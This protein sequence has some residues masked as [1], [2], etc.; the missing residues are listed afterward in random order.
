MIIRFSFKRQEKYVRVKKDRR[1]EAILGE[2]E[3]K[4]S[5]ITNVFTEAI[6]CIV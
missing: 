6:E 5:V 4:Y 1:R 2:N 3:I